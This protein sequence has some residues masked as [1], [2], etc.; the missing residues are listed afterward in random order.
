MTECFTSFLRFRRIPRRCL[1]P[2]VESDD[3]NFITF[4]DLCPGMPSI[5]LNNPNIT[6]PYY[7]SIRAGMA[8]SLDKNLNDIPLENKE[9][10][11][12]IDKYA[13]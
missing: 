13:E 4:F 1:F 10:E 3:N 8:I 11:K 6:Y 7:P 9:V 12:Y 2:A 5:I